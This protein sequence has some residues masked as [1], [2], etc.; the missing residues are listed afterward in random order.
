MQIV[1]DRR[2]KPPHAIN[3]CRIHIPCETRWYFIV[4]CGRSTEAGTG[5]L[6]DCH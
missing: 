2:D 1:S 4:R 5:G 6:D 3:S